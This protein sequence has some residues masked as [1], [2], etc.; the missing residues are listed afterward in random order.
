MYR[1]PVVGQTYRQEIKY[2][3]AEDVAKVLSITGSEITPGATCQGTCL[4]TKDFTPL[5]PESV[6]TKYYA[7]GVGKILEINKAGVGTE[8]IEFNHN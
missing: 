1:S 4:V 2:T 7:P 6:E 3:D 5:D 8:L